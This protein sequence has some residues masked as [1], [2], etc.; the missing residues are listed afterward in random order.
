ML[1]DS[2]I[3][4]RSVETALGPVQVE[5]TSGTGP[6]VLA[7]HAGIGGIDQARLMLDWLP[8]QDY[9]RLLVSRPG[10][11]DTPLA[12]RESFEQ[13]ADLFAAVLDALGLPQ[14]AV[15]TLS[16]GGPPGYLFAARHPE[17]VTALV[18]ISSVSGH[19]EQAHAPGP[20]AQ[21]LFTSRFGEFI[22]TTMARRAPRQLVTQLLRAESS[23]TPEQVRTQAEH[24]LRTPEV[25]AWLRAFTDTLHPYRPRRPGT[26]N[27]TAQLARTTELPLA[28]VRCPTLIVHGT[29]DADV[30][31]EHGVRAHEQIPGAQR[32]WIESGSHLGFWLAPTAEAARARAREFLD[33][34]CGQP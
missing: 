11:L 16:S 33:H 18:A 12:G 8:D 10:Y 13:Q 34:H 20:V 31:I 4:A 27:D 7:S 15:A 6:V 14:V 2:A 28:D 1:P 17:R 30:P 3:G 32:H 19:H 21:A 9:R 29:H 24:V 23:L 25:L 5:L 22:T 26:D